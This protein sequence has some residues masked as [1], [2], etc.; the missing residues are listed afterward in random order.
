M[1]D[2]MHEF[3]D[4]TGD[5]EP[6]A[7][8]FRHIWI[9]P[10]S[11]R[12]WSDPKGC[13]PSATFAPPAKGSEETEHTLRGTRLHAA[14]AS[15]IC[16]GAD[17]PRP[18]L[19]KGEWAI[20]QRAVAEIEQHVEVENYDWRV[21]TKVGREMGVDGKQGA[22]VDGT[23]DLVG[24][25]RSRGWRG[26]GTHLPEPRMI[27]IDLKFGRLAVEAEGNRQLSAYAVLLLC[28]QDTWAHQ[29]GQWNNADL[30][31]T[32]IVQPA[33][34]DRGAG[35]VSKSMLTYEEVVAEAARLDELIGRMTDPDTELAFNPSADNC[36]YC[37]GARSGECPEVVK[38]LAVAEE[39]M[40]EFG[41]IPPSGYA[42]FLRRCDLVAEM[43][44]HVRED[45]HR[46]LS[47][48][49][50]VAGM[51]LVAGRQGNRRWENEQSCAKELS[52]IGDH[53]GKVDIYT[54]PRLKSP[55][56][57]EREFRSVG[58]T[59]SLSVIADH[60]VRPPATTTVAYADDSAPSLGVRRVQEAL[61]HFK[62]KANKGD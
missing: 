21:E 36:R 40:V 17:N 50:E 13:W 7:G 11:A 46:R 16:P 39:R 58:A 20:A 45:A 55:A 47:R 61:E 53:G 23:P 6:K 33:M 32:M 25:A 35:M 18:S 28:G 41:L 60:Y 62:A 49:E 2:P 22:F 59:T 48:K 51:K 42:D 10:S 38:S 43:A 56:V 34:E 8:G 9:R 19:E 14:V 12:L 24:L 37:Q 29:G 27:V 3:P 52:A 5:P 31:R 15:I 44:K 4:H 54:E 26:R 30:V 1:S 57:L